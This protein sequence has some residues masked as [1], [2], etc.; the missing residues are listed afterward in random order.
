L[1][2]LKAVGGGGGGAVDGLWKS[3]A[4][5]EVLPDSISAT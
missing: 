2:G 3:I 4:N 1:R 5:D